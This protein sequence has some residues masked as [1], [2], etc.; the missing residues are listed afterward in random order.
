MGVVPVDKKARIYNNTK[1]KRVS[2]LPTGSALRNLFRR[3]L[4]SQRPLNCAA[5]A[6]VFF[7]AV[8]LFLL[9]SSSRSNYALLEDSHTLNVEPNLAE[10]ERVSI[11]GASI[12]KVVDE[13]ELVDKE[14]AE[15]L[16]EVGGSVGSKAKIKL[17]Y[18]EISKW[19]APPKLHLRS[20]VFQP[21]TPGPVVVSGFG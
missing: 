4:K 6:V 5:L 19:D 21:P 20:G 11:V 7:G 18:L 17:D 16:A 8:F 9:H 12:R 15:E 2:S 10:L 3:C 1:R 13:N 14:D